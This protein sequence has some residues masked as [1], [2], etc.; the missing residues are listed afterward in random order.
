[1]FGKVLFKFK[2]LFSLFKR[3][4]KSDIEDS[5]DDELDQSENEEESS[6]HKSEAV[7]STEAG[8]MIFGFLNLN[9]CQTWGNPNPSSRI[10]FHSFVL[11]KFL[12]C[13]EF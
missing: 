10:D 11:L 6:N 5:E 3:N 2:I 1:M 7:I 9:H 12:Q 4:D 13:H 8:I